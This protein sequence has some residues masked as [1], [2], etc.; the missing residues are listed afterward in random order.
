MINDGTYT[1]LWRQCKGDLKLFT[2]AYK[3]L[4]KTLSKQ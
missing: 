3:E 1:V 2:Q 4:K